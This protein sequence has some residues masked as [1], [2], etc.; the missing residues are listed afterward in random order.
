LEAAL[1]GKS[2]GLWTWL[3]TTALFGLWHVGY[4]DHLLRVLPLHS[5]TASLG[6]VLIWKVII[7]GAV[8]FLAGWVRWRSGQVYGALLVHGLWN[9]FG[10]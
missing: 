9:L 3:L 5:E 2:A 6:V 4:V 7:G 1:S 8:G 10:R